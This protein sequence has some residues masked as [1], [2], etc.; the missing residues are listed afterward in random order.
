M[1][2]LMN[3]AGI[4]K[5][6]HIKPD[7]ANE[8]SKSNLAGHET[9]LAMLVEMKTKTKLLLSVSLSVCLSPVCLTGTAG[10]KRQATPATSSSPSP[11]RL[12]SHT[13]FF[14]FTTSYVSA[15]SLTPTPPAPCLLSLRAWICALIACHT[16][17]GQTRRMRDMNMP[18][19]KCLNCRSF[20]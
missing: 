9:A 3:I 8:N 19:S 10:R 17:P 5:E 14:K 20:A 11:T 12:N 1:C 4:V 7:N 16:S 6:L 15:V 13:F 2:Q 18:R